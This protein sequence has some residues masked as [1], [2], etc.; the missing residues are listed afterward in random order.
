[1]SCSRNHGRSI[2]FRCCAGK[3]TKLFAP[4]GRFEAGRDGDL[5]ST[6]AFVAGGAMEVGSLV[7]V[8]A[9]GAAGGARPAA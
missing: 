7:A 4:S 5:V 9:V 3:F 6:R 8:S 2:I 1:M